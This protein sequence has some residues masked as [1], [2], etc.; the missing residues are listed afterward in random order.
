MRK[1]NS[2]SFPHI[3]N[4]LGRIIITQWYTLRA[5]IT[6]R[7]WGVKIGPHCVFCGYPCF[8]RHP[9]SNITIGA[10]CKFNSAPIANYLGVNRPCILSTLKEGADITIGYGCG[11]SGTFIACAR[12]IELGENVR[13]GAN[14]LIM[15]TDW[16]TDDART[17]PDAPVIIG[18]NVWLGVNV[19]VLKGVNIGENTIV[20]A[21]SIVMRSL[22]ANAVA[23]GVPARIVRKIDVNNGELLQTYDSNVSLSVRC[24]GH[25]G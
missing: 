1:L 18:N 17:S 6:A 9:R 7:W 4:C 13:C 20:G 10:S 25:V 24:S 19:T 5:C 16:H 3:V 2:D 8:K 22:P 14:T 23:M 11:F 21:G 12:H 15:D